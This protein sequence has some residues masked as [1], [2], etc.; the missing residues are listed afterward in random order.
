M[1]KIVRTAELRAANNEE[2]TYEFVISTEDVDRHGTVFKADGW[3]FDH[4]R[5]NPVVAYNHN[6]HS[7][8]P[9]DIIGTSEIRQEGTTTI[10]VLTLEPEGENPKADKVARKI[11]NGTLKM[12]SVGASIHDGH[13]GDKRDNENENV[14]YFTKQELHEWSVVTIGSNREALK[15]SD[16]D[17][18]E[19]MNEHKPA[20]LKSIEFDK[21][22]RKRNN[23]HNKR[24]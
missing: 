18:E 4:Y 22:R 9:D 6:T 3:N 5:K 24:K 14:F 11:A 8:D 19:F 10:G 21:A 7:N 17:I 23:I 16:A 1:K 20:K 15:R 12:A 13:W 2:R